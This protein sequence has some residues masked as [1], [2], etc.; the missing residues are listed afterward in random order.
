MDRAGRGGLHYRHPASAHRR[1]GDDDKLGADRHLPFPGL[2][3]S[4]GPPPLSRRRRAGGRG[5]MSAAATGRGAAPNAG[6]AAPI[7][8][9]VSLSFAYPGGGAVLRDFSLSVAPG[10]MVAVLGANGAGKSTALNLLSGYLRPASGAARL[11]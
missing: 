11:A 8:E 7:L 3:G 10:E 2:R 1:R 6:P 9:A 4:E 5:R